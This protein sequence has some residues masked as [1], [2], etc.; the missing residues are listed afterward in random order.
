MVDYID[1]HYILWD[2]TYDT[3]GPHLYHWGRSDVILHACVYGLHG[4]LLT[5]MHKHFHDYLMRYILNVHLYD[6]FMSLHDLYFVIMMF[7]RVQYQQWN[8][9]IAWFQFLRKQV[10]GDIQSQHEKVILI[11]VEK[12]Q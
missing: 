7:G 10:G 3:W 2:H 8:P 9:R 4:D 12:K 6:V 1:A 11:I 5:W